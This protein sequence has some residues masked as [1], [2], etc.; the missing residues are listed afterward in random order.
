MLKRAFSIATA[1]LAAMSLLATPVI[2]QDDIAA[3]NRADA[4]CLTIFLMAFGLEDSGLDAEAQMGGTVLIGYY[5]G[6]LE[7]RS[8]GFALEPMLMDVLTNDMVTEEQIEGIATRCGEDAKT[9]ADR[10]ISVG[11]TMGG[12]SE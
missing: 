12:I 6:K 3:A 11:N 1:S 8:P 5:L 2:A 9:M 7:A 10:M 4:Q